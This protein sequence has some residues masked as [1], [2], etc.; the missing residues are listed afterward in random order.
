MKLKK[1][2]STFMA[3]GLFIMTAMPAMAFTISP[4]TIAGHDPITNTLD[5]VSSDLD[6]AA[7]I[8]GEIHVVGLK[9]DE[10]VIV[11][12]KYNGT[13]WDQVDTIIDYSL[14]E[15]SYG[16]TV[17]EEPRIATDSAGNPAIAWVQE[18][19][20]GAHDVMYAESADGGTNWSEPMFVSTIMGISSGRNVDIKFDSSSYPTIVSVNIPTDAS[21]QITLWRGSR[22][23]GGA[24][25]DLT[26]A[27]NATTG[28]AIA[29]PVTSDGPGDITMEIDGLDI[30]ILVAPYTLSGPDV[31][32]YYISVDNGATWTTE[33]VPNVFGVG[34]LQV[35][36]SSQSSGLEQMVRSTIDSDGIFS[37]VVIDDQEG[38]SSDNLYYLERTP[39]I[40]GT[41]SGEVVYA[42]GEGGFD[43]AELHVAITSAG[44]TEYVTYSL[45][46]RDWGM[47][48]E[49][50][51][52]TLGWTDDGSGFDP[53]QTV[54]QY[55]YT[56]D[57]TG[58]PFSFTST[59]D[60]DMGVVSYTLT[61]TGPTTVELITTM[62]SDGEGGGGGE[63][64][65]GTTVWNIETSSTDLTIIDYI[66]LDYLTGTYIEEG[67]YNDNPV[68]HYNTGS[69]D[70]YMFWDNSSNE[71][72]LSDSV[73]GGEIIYLRVDGDPISTEVD[74][75][76]I[77]S[78][79]WIYGG[80]AY[81]DT[82]E[83][84]TG[85]DYTVS[86]NSYDDG[87]NP[88]FSDG[89]G[90]DTPYSFWVTGDE[91]TEL[92]LTS[93]IGDSINCSIGAAPTDWHLTLA[94]IDMGG[95]AYISMYFAE[96][97]FVITDATSAQT[98]LDAWSAVEAGGATMDLLYYK[99]DAF[100]Y[101][102]IED[103]YNFFDATESIVDLITV[104]D[105]SDQDFTTM[106]MSNE[107]GYEIPA[108]FVETGGEDSGEGCTGSADDGDTYISTFHAYSYDNSDDSVDNGIDYDAWMDPG[109]G[110]IAFLPD[111]TVDGDPFLTVYDED[112][113]ISCGILDYA[114][115]DNMNWHLVLVHAVDTGQDQYF[116]FYVNGDEFTG[117]D[118]AAIKTA[119]QNYLDLI[120]TYWELDSMT[121]D[122]AKK[123]A[124]E[125][126]GEPNVDGTYTLKAAELGADRV[127]YMTGTSAQEI[128][129][130]VPAI[131]I[132]GGIS[133]GEPVPEFKDYLLIL[134][135]A[136]ALGLAYTVIPKT[137]Q[138]RA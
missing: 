121:V 17:S 12:H 52:P 23:V 26:F 3:L 14:P 114:S 33:T 133:E 80:S 56:I 6:S 115:G 68:Y 9:S 55:H 101:D 60:H 21:D 86:T 93:S 109:Y 69:A 39:G 83:S 57:T 102:D 123:D 44:Q 77:I 30:H 47:R 71:W 134:T 95:L 62:D 45:S 32:K 54:G 27:D 59:Q 138:T 63:E 120:Y 66:D 82:C 18:N 97:D 129:Y 48:V 11:Y 85:Y 53:P 100:T 106:M 79:E 78:T 65:V 87:V 132:S 25:I 91:S 118:D 90:S 116:G 126:S 111:T 70:Y 15:Y 51:D 107:T 58:T 131:N 22:V 2:L 84:G 40:S 24:T 104:K 112:Q 35:Q 113:N 137:Q 37:F 43:L 92:S 16:V 128:A 127:T 74:I 105:D 72:D 81:G 67:A 31:L 108:I 135:I 61:S 130:A 5:D 38:A 88:T 10:T 20:G 99:L 7:G 1:L 124:L 73:G 50:N 96:D 8:S 75:Q 98:A 13:S 125:Y 94:T 42:G 76:S 49:Y 46:Y 19:P 103:K 136:L 64:V 117:S 4:A 34:D 28:T 110:G 119:A 29:D 89:D 122:Y 41:W 36:Q